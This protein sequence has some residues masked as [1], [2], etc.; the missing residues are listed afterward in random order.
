MLANGVEFDDELVSFE[1]WGSSEKQR[2]KESGE[3]PAGAR[4]VCAWKSQAIAGVCR[5]QFALC[6]SRHQRDTVALGQ[7]D[8]ATAPR[9]RTADVC[10]ASAGVEGR[11]QVLLGAHCHL[12]LH[13]TP[14]AASPRRAA[15]GLTI[16]AFLWQGLELATLIAG[17]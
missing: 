15:T 14:G 16:T 9:M 4:R 6:A 10:R 7:E 1:E 5:I 17:G 13:C 11:G 8:G 2:M 3:Q 12:S